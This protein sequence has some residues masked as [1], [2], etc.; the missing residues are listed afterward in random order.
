MFFIIIIIY[1]ILFVS[2]WYFNIGVNID[3]IVFILLSIKTLKIHFNY[4]GYNFYR[5]QY[6]EDKSKNIKIGTRC[7][8]GTLLNDELIMDRIYVFSIY[9]H[10]FARYKKYCFDCTQIRVIILKF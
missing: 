10:Y 6:Y 5:N 9:T 8:D 2:S 1:S 4:Y 3:W 7:P